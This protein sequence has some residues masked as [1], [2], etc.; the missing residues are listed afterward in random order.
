MP[1]VKTHR[2]SLAP[3]S[4]WAPRATAASLIE[5]LLCV[6]RMMHHPQTR[7]RRTVRDCVLVRERARTQ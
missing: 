6:V 5:A 7:V 2:R 1:A 4:C 3:A